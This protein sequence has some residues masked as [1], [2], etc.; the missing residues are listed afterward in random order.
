[1]K[2]EHVGLRHST[3]QEVTYG[4]LDMHEMDLPLYYVTC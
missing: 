3:R 1:M 4:L 2:K